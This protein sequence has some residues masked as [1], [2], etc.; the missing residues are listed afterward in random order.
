MKEKKNHKLDR[1]RCKFPFA[2]REL[3]DQ[4]ADS[5]IVLQDPG[6]RYCSYEKK[7]PKAA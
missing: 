3:V 7:G 1:S 5:F 4:I 6:L 2:A